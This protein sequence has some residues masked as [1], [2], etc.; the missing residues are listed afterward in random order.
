[1]CN[2]M[3]KRLALF[4]NSFH[5]FQSFWVKNAKIHVFKEKMNLSVVF[6]FKKMKC[7]LLQTGLLDLKKH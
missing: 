4:W 2:V 1:M 6:F 5:L 7:M 3:G